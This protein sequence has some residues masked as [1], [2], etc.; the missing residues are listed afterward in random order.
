MTNTPTLFPSDALTI[1][2]QCYANL[3]YNPSLDVT[4]TA[5]GTNEVTINRSTGLCVFTQVISGGGRAIFRLNN[6]LLTSSSVVEW[7][8]I[9]DGANLVGFPTP[10]FYYYDSNEGNFDVVNG[11]VGDDT[12]GD[13][14]IWFKIIG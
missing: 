8:I 9:Y 3:L 13:I 5:T 14:N 12:N 2:D 10:R 7:G 4:N 11:S 1:L 6:N